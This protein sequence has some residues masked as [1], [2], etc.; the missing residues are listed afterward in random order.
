MLSR[1]APNDI[2]HLRWIMLVEP[3]CERTIA[4]AASSKNGSSSR[5]LILPFPP[6]LPSSL[7]G[8]GNSIGSIGPGCS[9]IYSLMRSISGVS[10]K[11]H[12]T[13]TG[14]FPCDC[15]FAA[16]LNQH[17]PAQVQ[18]RLQPCRTPDGP[19]GSCWHRR[20]STGQ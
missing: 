4:W 8:S 20:C 14:S 19:D 16:R 17:D 5:A 18:Y 15:S 10:T 13:R 3:C 11:A 9:Q 2:V 7:A 1:F 6:A 12:C